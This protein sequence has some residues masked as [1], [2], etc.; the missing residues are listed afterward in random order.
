MLCLRKM[1]SLRAREILLSI[2]EVYLETGEA[3]GSNTIAKRLEYSLSPATI[4]NTMVELTEEGLLYS[5]HISAGRLPT[6]SGLRIYVDYLLTQQEMN[7]EREKKHGAF[8]H[9]LRA[10]KNSEALTHAL[11]E[12][13]RCASILL[14]SFDV[15]IIN[16]V[17]LMKLDDKRLMMIFITTDGK[18]YNRLVHLSQPIQ[19]SE[20]LEAMNFLTALLKGIDLK[21][22]KKRIQEALRD[23]CIKVNKLLIFLSESSLEE[24]FKE[25]EHNTLIVKGQSNLLNEVSSLK[26]VKDLQ[27]VLTTLEKK[28]NFIRLLLD[29]SD[30]TQIRVLFGEENNLLGRTGC[31]L[32]I[33]PYMR[34]DVKGAVGII[35]PSRLDYARVISMVDYAAKTLEEINET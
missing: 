6:T 22:I 21:R 3:V 24:W 9:A 8:M 26:E 14:M 5:P 10:S 1:N 27:D 35:G 18:A 2:I 23:E 25:I 17:G 13:S 11:S 33:A 30:A 31:S 7:K 34:E 16:K 32:V 4:R 28:E 29:I 20:L 15:H 19:E 12:S